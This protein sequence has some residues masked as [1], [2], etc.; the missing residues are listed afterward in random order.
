MEDIGDA[1]NDRT[2]EAKQLAVGS[3]YYRAQGGDDA[4]NDAVREGL[5]VRVKPKSA[6][7]GLV[8]TRDVPLRLHLP[9]VRFFG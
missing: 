6:A 8:E 2:A 4:T 3:A 9:D 5:V 7:E 1:F